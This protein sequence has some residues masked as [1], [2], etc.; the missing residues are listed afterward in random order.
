MNPPADGAGSSAS[1]GRPVDGLDTG[2]SV[3]AAPAFS[4]PLPAIG[5]ARRHTRLA[6]VEA[7]LRDGHAQ[8]AEFQLGDGEGFSGAEQFALRGRR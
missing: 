5:I 8:A 4:H 6:R 1:A 3:T 2:L 7:F